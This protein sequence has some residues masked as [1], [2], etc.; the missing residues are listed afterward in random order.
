MTQVPEKKPLS[1]KKKVVIGCGACIVGLIGLFVLLLIVA[2]AV[3][4]STSPGTATDSSQNGAQEKD[5][6]VYTLGEPFKVG[7]TSYTVHGVTW[8]KRLGNAYFGEDADARYLLVD[9]T[10]KNEDK[11]NRMIPPFTLQDGAGLS[12]DE[13][14]NSYL[15]GNKHLTLYSLNPGVQRRGT[16][17][18]DIPPENQYRL[19]VSGGV[20]SGEAAIVPLN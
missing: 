5:A 12:Y 13:S 2:L 3:G 20:W 7:Y 4:S 16:L 6:A 19:V 11:E 1:V 18:F 15:L 8:K 14:H 9:V 10:I 17:V